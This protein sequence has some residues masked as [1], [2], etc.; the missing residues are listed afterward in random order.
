MLKSLGQWTTP[1]KLRK[2]IPSKLTVVPSKPPPS[3]VEQESV[4][5]DSEQRE[6][7]Y[8]TIIAKRSD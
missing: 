2:I 5:Q 6:T 4:V 8:V 1:I 3:D 7:E